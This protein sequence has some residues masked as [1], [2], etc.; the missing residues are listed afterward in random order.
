MEKRRSRRIQVELKAERLSGDARSAVFIENISENGIYMIT[1][2]SRNT[3][4][5]PPGT[6]VRLKLQLSPDETVDIHCNV[7][8]SYQNMP[9][10]GLTNS[11]GMEIIKPPLK[12][13]RF[14]Q[15]LQ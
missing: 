9:P 6:K 8:W 14:I 15:S 13:R 3:L 11:V 12:Y 5:C 1:A 10:D 2:P 7:I 4:S